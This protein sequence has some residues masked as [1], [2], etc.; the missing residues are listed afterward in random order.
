MQE[1]CVYNELDLIEACKRGHLELVR[2][3]LRD[4]RISREAEDSAC[5]YWACHNGHTEIVHAL[6]WDDQA[7]PSADESGALCAAARFGHTDIVRMLL[8]HDVADPGARR[9]FP[10]IIACKN[11]HASVVC[12]LLHSPRVE[13]AVNNG[14]CLYWACKRGHVDVVRA[15]IKDGRVFSGI[16]QQRGDIRWDCRA[17]EV[18]CKHNRVDIV[19]ILLEANFATQLGVRLACDHGHDDVVRAVIARPLIQRTVTNPYI[20]R[21][22]DTN[23]IT[24]PG[25]WLHRKYV[26]R[27]HAIAWCLQQ[28]NQSDLVYTFVPYFMNARIQPIETWEEYVTQKPA[29]SYAP[30]LLYGVFFVL[31]FCVLIVSLGE[32]KIKQDAT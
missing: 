5:L 3:I 12:I 13:P 11:G 28:A 8:Q 24:H 7:D 1:G 20:R 9:N 17:F 23:I 26:A 27:A 19:K 6:L 25:S 21:W 30:L 29:C 15:L 18:A 4:E 32:F 31:V 14:L 16:P 10:L 2:E 22:I